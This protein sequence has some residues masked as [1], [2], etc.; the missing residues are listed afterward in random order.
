MAVGF[1]DVDIVVVVA[2][3]GGGGGGEDRSGMCK[4]GWL[5]MSGEARTS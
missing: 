5:L 4:E 1:V 3:G 2:V